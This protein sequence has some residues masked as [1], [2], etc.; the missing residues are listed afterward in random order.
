V[1]IFKVGLPGTMQEFFFS[2][3]Y[4]VFYWM[5]GQVGTAELAATNV[6]VRISMVFAI[7]S[8][9]LGS[10]SATLVSKTVG[11]GDPAGAAQWGWDSGKLGVISIT[12]LALPLVLFPRFFLSIF[13]SDPH[14]ISIAVRPWQLVTALAG[15]GS[16][17]YI[18]AYTLV[19]V[20]DGSRVVMISFGTQWLL[21]LP[22]VWIVGPYLYYG[23]L[24]IS[25]IQAAYGALAASLITAIWAQGRWKKIKI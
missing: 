6:Q 11:E 2:A 14:A 1:R 8:M 20:G 18:F 15:L 13:L 19:S 21:S 22:A 12:L 3:G 7:L 10:A 17:I 24:Q 5:I 25:F 16:L 9:S 4:I 23:L